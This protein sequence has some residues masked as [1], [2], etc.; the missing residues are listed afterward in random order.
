MKPV[1]LGERLCLA[2]NGQQPGE[3]TAELAK[4]NCHKGSGSKDPGR[5]ARTYIP[6]PHVGERNATSGQKALPA[7]AIPGSSRV[8]VEIRNEYM[9]RP[10]PIIGD[11]FRESLFLLTPKL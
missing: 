1:A 7:A 4:R 6:G 10:A 9:Q 8:D 11:A 2:S 5:R 3:L